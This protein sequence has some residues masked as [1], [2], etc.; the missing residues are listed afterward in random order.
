MH[1]LRCFTA[2]ASALSAAQLAA[3][4]GLPLS[5]M[6]R[7]LAQLTGFGLLE[8]TPGH[9]YTIGLRLWELGELSPLSLR[10]RETALPHMLRLYE[11]TGENVHLAVLDGVTPEASTAL[12]VGRVTGQGSIPTLSRMGG[13]Q[14]LHTTGVGKALLSTRDEAWLA[15]YFT[16][17]LQ[18]E[19]TR[20]ITDEPRLRDE[21]ERARSRGYAT[22]REEMT[23]GNVS[24]AAALPRVDGLPPI[25]L[26]LVVHLERADERRLA[27]LVQQTARDLHA[28][29]RAR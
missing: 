2:D 12:F 23:L 14:P 29:L 16:A 24:V 13:R 27:P 25:A 22:T 17:P 1:V 10:L 9:T 11:A 6:H 28:D 21:I 5:T 26:G 4:T 7:L 8:R 3:Q 19:T 20:S 18:R 15:H